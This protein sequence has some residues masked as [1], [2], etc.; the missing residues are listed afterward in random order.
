MVKKLK[1]RQKMLLLPGFATS[2]FLI[3][4][5]VSWFLGMRN[6]NLLGRIETGYAPALELSQELERTLQTVQRGMQ[7]AVAAMDLEALDELESS[8]KSFLAFL[9]RGEQNPVLEPAG[10]DRIRTAFESYYRITR[11]ASVRMING[12]TGEGL[13]ATLERMRTSYNQLTETLTS[14]TTRNK[15]VMATAFV[16]TRENQRTSITAAAV[17]TLLCAVLL[18]GL[19]YV[20]GRQVA[21]PIASLS[22]AAE[23]IAVE[24]MASLAA[25]AKLMAEGDLTRR[26]SCSRRRVAVESGGEVGRMASS[27][28]LMVEKLAEISS[29][30]NMLSSGLREIVVHVQGAADTVADGS[31]A[32]ARATGIAARGNE[33]TV[34]AVEGIASTLHQ[35]SANIQNVAHNAQSQASTTGQALTSIESLLRSVQVV[36]TAAGKLVDIS[37]NADVAATRGGEAMEEATVGMGEIHDVI[38]TSAEFMEE[39]GAMAQ[40][41][42][43]IVGVIDD[44]A[45][46]TNL[47]ALNASIEAARAGEHGLGFAVVADEVLKLAERSARST[48]EISDL[49]GNIQR[50]VKKAVKNME[51][52]TLIVERGRTRTDELKTHLENIRSSVTEVA[53]CSR[54]IGDATT[55]QSAGTQQIEG[56]TSRLSELTQEISVATE[57]QSKGAELVVQSIESIR[58]MVQ[59][60]AEG[61]AELASSSEELSRQ[62]DLMRELTSRFYIGGSSSPAQ[63]PAQ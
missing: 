52:S 36:T 18:G 47:L 4:F 1:I 59:E 15:E 17:A 30:F 53:L 55:E 7:D 40:D 56:A 61:A 23:R 10:L 58:D 62:A 14:N 42:G 51:E 37:G 11:D 29:A 57:E 32:V 54:E 43:K 38:R 6:E 20:I 45:E 27:F 22:E 63:K 44:I 50:Q 33:S 3:I 60:N 19:S 9:D 46:Q 12:E 13:T 49:I 28:N 16:S 2:G 41:I 8:R 24:D 5:F 34:S 21:G 48:S 25:E 26:T 31:K 35:M 39:L